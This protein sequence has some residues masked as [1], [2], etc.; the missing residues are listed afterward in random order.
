MKFSSEVIEEIQNDL[1]TQFIP[2]ITGINC[3]IETYC[4][5]L[6]GILKEH[7]QNSGELPQTLEV[8]DFF[9]DTSIVQAYL[10]LRVPFDIQMNNM[11]NTK[12]ITLKPSFDDF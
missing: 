5:K 11:R 3:C 9:P 6:L 12:C 7:T 1:K 2:V 4:Y 10:R 8:P